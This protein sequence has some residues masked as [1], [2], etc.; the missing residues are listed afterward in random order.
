MSNSC[1]NSNEGIGVRVR[2][3]DGGFPFIVDTKHEMNI[4]LDITNLCALAFVVWISTT[5][6][7]LLKIGAQNKGDKMIVYANVCDSCWQENAP[8]KLRRVRFWTEDANEPELF[9]LVKWTVNVQYIH[10]Q[11]FA[12]QFF[13]ELFC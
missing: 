9:V 2:V 6:T 13:L 10:G 8:T 5:S 1:V 4:R 3:N 7:P 11:Q 12:V